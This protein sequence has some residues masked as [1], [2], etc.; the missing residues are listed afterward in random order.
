MMSRSAC[1]DAPR[2][3][4]KLL[5][6]SSSKPHRSARASSAPVPTA[7]S[8]EDA[9][10]APGAPHPAGTP[11]L[12]APRVWVQRW[13][14]PPQ[15]RPG[16]RPRRAPRL[17]ARPPAPGAPGDW[18]VGRR[19]GA[20]RRQGGRGAGRGGAGRRVCQ[21]KVTRAE[22]G[23]RGCRGAGLEVRNSSCDWKRLGPGGELMVPLGSNRPGE[24]SVRAGV[25]PARA[26]A[27][28]WL[29]RSRRESGRGGRG[30]AVPGPRGYCRSQARPGY[31]GTEPRGRE[32]VR[33]P[34]ERLL[35]VSP[36]RSQT[37]RPPPAFPEGLGR[38]QTSVCLLLLLF[39][40]PLFPSFR[41]LKRRL[42]PRGALN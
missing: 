42:P 15:F 32:I 12:R 36:G 4:A 25:R 7:P 23:T 3:V 39:M 21:A 35:T 17:R 30:L 5:R 31:W 33:R 22:G 38:P 14:R 10:L 1:S 28:H 8:A 27:S 16:A 6:L 41:T 20:S 18:S 2:D 29:R 11:Q 34:R 37:V 24:E 19:G 26:L 13:R 9:I 40:H